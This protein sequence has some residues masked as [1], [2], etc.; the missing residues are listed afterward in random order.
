MPS[1]DDEFTVV[2]RACYADVLRFIRRRVEVDDADEVA[3]EVFTIA[4]RRWSD[5][6]ADMRPWLFGIAHKVL[7]G[8]HRTWRRRRTL[9]L[10]VAAQPATSHLGAGSHVDEAM[11]LAAAWSR[12]SDQDRESI[13]LVAWDGLTGEQA[14]VV[15]GC[16]RSAFAVRLSRARRRFDAE[17]ERADAPPAARASRTTTTKDFLAA[18]PS[19]IQKLPT[20]QGEVR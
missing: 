9:A 13:A 3:A 16:S 5:A 1:A 19:L 2:Y 6:P 4:W 7:S 18:G 14:A 11:D 17:L 8:A 20:M 15:L 12:L 10:R